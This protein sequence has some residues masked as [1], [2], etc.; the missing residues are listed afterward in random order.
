[1][2]QRLQA[3][4]TLVLLG[5]VIFMGVELYRGQRANE[6]AT[7]LMTQRLEDLAEPAV[8]QTVPKTG[9]LSVDPSLTE[10]RATY[11]KPMMDKTWSWCYDP[12]QLK[13]TGEPHYEADGETCVLPVKLEPGKTYT[14]HL[15][16]ESFHNFKDATGRSAVPYVLQFATRQ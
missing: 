11:N 10:I 14:I 2:L 15:N 8:V 9:D 1:M 4:L 5:A 16:S 3:V 6:A 13:T 7:A 12:D